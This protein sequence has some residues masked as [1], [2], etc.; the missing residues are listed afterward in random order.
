MTAT[1]PAPTITSSIVTPY[2]AASAVRRA[3]AAASGYRLK[4]STSRTRASTEGSGSNGFSLE[5]SLKAS[6]AAAR[7]CL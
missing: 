5:E 7:P 3:V 6:A 4:S 2:S 1:E